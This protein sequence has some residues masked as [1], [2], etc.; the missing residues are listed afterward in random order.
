LVNAA[1]LQIEQRQRD[2]VLPPGPRSTDRAP[3]AAH[4]KCGFN[5]TDHG[6]Q[7]EPLHDLNDRASRPSTYM[8]KRSR[9]PGLLGAA[10]IMAA[11]MGVAM[12]A[13]HDDARKAEAQLD[14]GAS[15][16]VPAQP[17][18]ETAQ[19]APSQDSQVATQPAP[20]RR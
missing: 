4:A 3:G 2:A 5:A 20:A 12:W 1:A 9:W 13:Q 11:V 19:P 18:S 14:K 8:P 7:M 17:G 15:V 10:A 6:A 16:A